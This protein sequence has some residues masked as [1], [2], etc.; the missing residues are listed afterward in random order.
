[1]DISTDAIDRA[2]ETTPLRQIEQTLLSRRS[3]LR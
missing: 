1:M 3:R 2:T